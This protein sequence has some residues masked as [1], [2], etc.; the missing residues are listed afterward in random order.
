MQQRWTLNVRGFGKLG[1]AQLRLAPF[2]LLVGENNTGKSYLMT[3][4]W[5]VFAQSR[6]IFPKT[7][8]SSNEYKRCLELFLAQPEQI[9]VELQQAL[10]EW[11]NAILAR[12]KNRLVRSVLSFDKAEIAHLSISDYQRAKPFAL[13]WTDKN[14]ERRGP[15]SRSYLILSHGMEYRDGDLKNS[16][17]KQQ[18]DFIRTVCW[19]YVFGDLSQL[20]KGFKPLY[21]PAARSGFMLSYSSLITNV[22]KAWGGQPIETR[23]SQPVIEFLKNLA[24]TEQAPADKPFDSILRFFQQKLLS[25]EVTQQSVAGLN[26][27]QYL[28][29]NSKQA[30]P[31]HVVSS[32]V[33]ELSPILILLRARLDFNALIIEE[34]E[35]HL[36]PKLQRLFVQVIARLVNMGIPV[37]CT[38]H[39]D[40]VF[41][42]V[43]NLIKLS[44]HPN[45]Y[46]LMEEFDYSNE[47]IL[48]LSTIEAYE[49]VT[50]PDGTTQVQS[51]KSSIDG[52]AVPS[53][54]NELL[55]LSKETIA[56]MQDD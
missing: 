28:A 23:F 46:E 31:Y 14:I 2:M 51:L 44:T 42:Q 48:H 20:S 5:G 15:F 40:T 3:L 7:V 35:A 55:A 33:G 24:T 21:F 29:K 49:C 26:Q 36:H 37:W 9:T 16:N 13:R 39:S 4:L 52:Y 34:P 30:L 32:L 47:D 43:N 45:Q 22:M 56:F 6:I 12:Q 11:L 17:E 25:G 27:Y 38:T 50:A 8:P 53:F 1:N 10:I 18:Y 41:Q 19:Q 54:N